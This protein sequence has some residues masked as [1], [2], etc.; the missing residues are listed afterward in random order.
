[1][2]V[3]VDVD[4]DVIVNGLNSI[5]TVESFRETKKFRVRSTEVSQGFMFVRATPARNA[6]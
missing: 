2:A 1:V 4:V 3:V 5:L 6:L